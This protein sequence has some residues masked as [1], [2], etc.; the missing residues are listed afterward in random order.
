LTSPA[1]PLPQNLT[2]LHHS[3]LFDIILISIF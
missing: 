3:S 2:R 1:L